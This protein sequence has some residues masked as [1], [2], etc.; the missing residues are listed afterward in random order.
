VRA[1]VIE[2]AEINSGQCIVP[3]LKY[4][5]IMNARIANI[6]CLPVLQ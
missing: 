2:S 5:A 3:P 4:D 6:V 1:V